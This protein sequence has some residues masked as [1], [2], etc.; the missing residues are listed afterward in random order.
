M[1]QHFIAHVIYILESIESIAMFAADSPDGLSDQK[2]YD[3]V[4][5]RI[6]TLAESA[7]K[8]PDDIKQAHP[9]V[10]WRNFLTMRN[11]IAH[12]YLGNVFPEDIQ[13]F[14]ECEVA[15]LQ[16]AMQKQLPEW[17]TL[18]ARLQDS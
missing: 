7:C 15:L 14:I 6:Q 10:P 2:T 3:A 18:L 17:K 11:A 4:L 5:Y 12:D 9:T 8:L 16:A 13:R 1:T